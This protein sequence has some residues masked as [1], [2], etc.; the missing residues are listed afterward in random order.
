MR[1][2]A[3]P[4]SIRQLFGALIAL[5]LVFTPGAALA[6]ERSTPAAMPSHEMQM[7]DMGDC[8]SM[9][10]GDHDKM[11][12][13]RCVAAC[14]ALAVAPQE[15]DDF[16]P[17]APVVSYFGVPRI[18]RGHLGEIATPPPRAA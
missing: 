18:W 10:S 6:M 17:A 5:T 2:Y 13:E 15:P 12:K 14:I 1:A 3:N 8:Q 9:P 11:P 7:M 4:M 16:V